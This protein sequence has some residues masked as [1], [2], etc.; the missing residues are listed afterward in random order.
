[1]RYATSVRGALNDLSDLLDNIERGLNCIQ[2]GIAGPVTSIQGCNKPMRKP[3]LSDV[4]Y[5]LIVKKTKAVVRGDKPTR[6]R[7]KHT[8]RVRALQD[9]ER[10]YNDIADCAKAS[11][12]QHDL[13]S[14]Y[15]SIKTICGGTG[16]SQSHPI[17]KADGSFVSWTTGLGQG[18]RKMDREL[19]DCNE[20]PVLV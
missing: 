20:S 14:V 3:W 18:N 6:Y 15:R 13:E 19:R 16:N 4:A 11:L 1:L 17:S 5:Q 7:L 2:D 12:R 9:K 8:F 10:F